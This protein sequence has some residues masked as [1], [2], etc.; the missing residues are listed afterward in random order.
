MWGN[1][2]QL[3]RRIFFF[4][5]NN[6]EADAEPVLEAYCPLHAKDIACRR[7][8]SATGKS[9]PPEKR[10]PSSTK[11]VQLP[12]LE[13]KVSAT[14]SKKST[15]YNDENNII[16]NKTNV[17]L[18]T[19]E[20]SKAGVRTNQKR[21]SET[22]SIAASLQSPKKIKR[23]TASAA[24]LASSAKDLPIPPSYSRHS[25]TVSEPSTARGKKSS[26]SDTT[27]KKEA[28]SAEQTGSKKRKN[29]GKPSTTAS[30]SAVEQ[31]NHAQPKVRRR[32]ISESKMSE[33]DIYDDGFDWV[34]LMVA[35]VKKAFSIMEEYPDFSQ[36][37]FDSREYYWKRKSGIYGRDFEV[38]WSKVKDQI[39]V[40]NTKRSSTHVQSESSAM[41]DVDIDEA[42]VGTQSRNH[43][44]YLWKPDAAFFTF[45]DWDTV[46]LRSKQGAEETEEADNMEDA[47]MEPEDLML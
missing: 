11:I 38:I 39:K 1:E 28:L 44:D 25:T 34:G 16:S 18:S 33:D 32:Y 47:N 26:P 24:S 8:G 27:K 29:I 14:S 15:K 45:N 12:R 2:N 46:A 43:W 21:R 6:K 42:N 36:D 13:R 5:G 7:R 4:P 35:D 22:D 9:E 10:L 19:T 37:V 17:A 41:V 31:P 3:A 23:I 40:P 20:A 30:V